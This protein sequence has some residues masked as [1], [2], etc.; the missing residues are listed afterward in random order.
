MHPGVLLWT[1]IRDTDSLFEGILLPQLEYVVADS[2]RSGDVLQPAQCNQQ[3]DDMPCWRNVRRRV[4]RA[5]DLRC[6]ILLSSV[7]ERERQRDMSHRLHVS[8]RV[9]G[10]SV[11]RCGTVLQ[12]YR[13]G[14]WAPVPDWELL[15][16]RIRAPRELSRGH[17]WRDVDARA[18]N[19]LRPMLGRLLV[20]RGEHEQH[21]RCVSTGSSVWYRGRRPIAVPDRVLLP[22]TFH[23][24][25]H[26]VYRRIVL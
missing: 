18:W 17:V 23:G 8:G 1:R 22:P 6:A 19:L 25:P 11:L 3:H 9:R 13:D 10:T 24:F 26:A 5:R 7:V 21:R 4:H 14:G 20:P 12:L 2:M 15:C 16:V